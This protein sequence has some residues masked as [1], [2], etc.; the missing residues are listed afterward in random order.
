MSRKFLTHLD[1]AKNELQNAAIQ[2]LAAAPSSPVKGQLYFDTTGSILYWWDG[3]A[4]Q[5]AKGGASASFYDTVRIDGV[6]RTQRPVLN[7]VSTTGVTMSVTDDAVNTESE[8]RATPNYSTVTPQTTFGLAA[9]DGSLAF[10]ARSDH[11]HGTPVHDNAAHSAINLNALAA[12]T[13]DVPMGGFKLT[14][15][16]SPTAGTDATNKSYVDAMQ[17]GLSWKDPVRAATTANITLSGTQTIDGVALIANDRCLV[18]D[19]T[20][21]SANGIYTVQSGAWV[22]SVD[23]DAASELEGAAVFVMEGTTQDNTTWVM[24]ANAPITV[25]TTSLT[26]VQNGGASAA[27]AGAGLSA[28]G[29]VF[30][31]GAGTGITVAAD[32]VALDTAYTDGRYALVANAAKRMAGT[33]AAAVATVINHN[34]NTRNVLVDV[35]RTA[36]PYDT[37]DCDIE[38]TDANNVTV[39]FTT[40]PAS[41]EYTVV[42]MA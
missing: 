35:Y 5:S 10:L 29:N 40:A 16:G 2:N 3:T 15:V 9:S 7:F 42:V 38:R 17:Y 14:N 19:Q 25:G 21:Q 41:A 18:K 28:S 11:T 6:A 39:R 30:N 24:T 4:W 37:V 36:A 20:T 23:S 8:V 22:R 32:T 27:T 34:F 31:V 1:L 13:A 33:V 12:P 26:W